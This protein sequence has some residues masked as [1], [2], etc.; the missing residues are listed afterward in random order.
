ML[1]MK[2][3]ETLVRL[4]NSNT[5]TAR[6]DRSMMALYYFITDSITV[7]CFVTVVFVWHYIIL[8]PIQLL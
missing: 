5:A 3:R 6:H 7:A 4:E 8:L 1:E 2:V